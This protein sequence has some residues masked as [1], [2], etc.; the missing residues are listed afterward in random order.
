MTARSYAQGTSVA[1]A[2]IAEVVEELERLRADSEDD[3]DNAF[4]DEEDRA[5]ARGNEVGFA[6][7]LRLLRPLLETP[8]AGGGPPGPC[9]GAEPAGP[10]ASEE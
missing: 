3:A 2:R 5:E 6:R 9:A 8:D 4:G 1:V 7:A 10:A